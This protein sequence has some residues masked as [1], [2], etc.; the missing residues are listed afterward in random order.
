MQ[1]LFKGLIEY[2]CAAKK[3]AL[4]AGDD[5]QRFIGDGYS[6]A[7]LGLLSRLIVGTEADTRHA[8]AHGQASPE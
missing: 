1:P 6:E 8:L 4:F 5:A 2:L 7:D 3:D